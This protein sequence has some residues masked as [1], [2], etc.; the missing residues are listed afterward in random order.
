MNNL[1]QVLKDMEA[2]FA[3]HFCIYG[4]YYKENGDRIPRICKPI[5]PEAAMTWVKSWL[6]KVLE[7]SK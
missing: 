1:D 4:E 6:P 7:A 2:D 5:E 3:H